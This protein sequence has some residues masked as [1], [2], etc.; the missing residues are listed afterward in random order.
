MDISGGYNKDA[1]KFSSYVTHADGTSEKLSIF[2]Q[3][4]KVYDGS[5]I[6]VMKKEDVEPFSFTQYVTNLT[7]GVQFKWLPD[8]GFWVKSYEGFYEPGTWSIEF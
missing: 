4:P 6:T 5:I 7:T 8:S 1:A 2:G 3:N